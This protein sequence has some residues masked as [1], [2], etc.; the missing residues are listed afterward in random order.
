MDM[1]WFRGSAAAGTHAAH[2]ARQPMRRVD[3]GLRT[4]TLR[5]SLRFMNI[6]FAQG[7]SDDN[8]ETIKKRFHV[9]LDQSLPV[10]AAY[11][12]DGKVRRVVPCGDPHL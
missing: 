8:I 12:K 1:A 2:G 9:F 10:V 7:R 6:L 11:E 5:L 3:M 4:V